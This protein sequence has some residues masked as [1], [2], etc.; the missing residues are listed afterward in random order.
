MAYGNK[1]RGSLPDRSLDVKEQKLRC[2]LIQKR[3]YR[4]MCI[5]MVFV[6]WFLFGDI[7]GC[8]LQPDLDNSRKS[9]SRSLSSYMG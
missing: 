5:L 1:R 6:L 2:S 3:E 4:V 9:C 8:D 7:Q